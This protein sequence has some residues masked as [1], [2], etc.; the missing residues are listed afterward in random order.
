MYFLKS[1]IIYKFMESCQLNKTKYSFLIKN[2]HR[3]DIKDMNFILNQMKK[4]LKFNGSNFYINGKETIFKN[5]SYPGENI[6]F[7]AT[8]NWKLIILIQ[9]YKITE[10]GKTSPIW[11]IKEAKKSY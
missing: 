9:G 3:R 5:D 4:E 6:N 2:T 7:N 11:C 1:P 10:S 8:Q